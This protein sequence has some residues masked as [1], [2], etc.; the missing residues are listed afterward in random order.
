M[1]PSPGVFFPLFKYVIFFIGGLHSFGFSHIRGFPF[2]TMQISLDGVTHR[3][4]NS[5]WKVHQLF[6]ELLYWFHPGPRMRGWN[7]GSPGLCNPSRILPAAPLGG[8]FSPV[9]PFSWSDKPCLCSC[10]HFKNKTKR[11]NFLF[12]L[13]PLSYS[14]SSPLPSLL[15]SEA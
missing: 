11:N 8:A 1:L 9:W 15:S 7:P 5:F 4:Y 2:V 12:I 14:T 13:R 3:S 6:K 10:T